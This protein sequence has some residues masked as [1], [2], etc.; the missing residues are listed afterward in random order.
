MN[1]ETGVTRAWTSLRKKH[2]LEWQGTYVCVCV[3]K[4]GIKVF[5]C[6]FLNIRTFFNGFFLLL[7][8][9]MII[10][11][12]LTL[13]IGLIEIIKW[14]KWINMIHLFFFYL[15]FYVTSFYVCIPTICF[16][17]RNCK[18]WI[19]VKILKAWVLLQP[20]KKKKIIIINPNIEGI[21]GMGYILLLWRLCFL[22][23]CFFLFP[24]YNLIFF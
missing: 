24:G 2:A 1:V 7:Y 19:C 17:I 15:L 20:I 5:F 10:I 12:I 22:L 11:S 13:M 21:L 8:L 14:T 16:K 6:F 9:V 18:Y 4:R 3:Q 23:T